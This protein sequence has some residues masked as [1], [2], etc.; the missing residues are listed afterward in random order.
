MSTTSKEQKNA[1]KITSRGR[2]K[3]SFLIHDALKENQFFSIQHNETYLEQQQ[4]SSRRE[5]I[6]EVKF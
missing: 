1:I 6:V 5:R 4:S 3:K 2:E